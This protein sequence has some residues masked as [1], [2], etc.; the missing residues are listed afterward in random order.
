MF[1]ILRLC[2]ILFNTSKASKNLTFILKQD[3]R[4]PVYSGRF[5]YIW[6]NSLYSPH[7]CIHFLSPTRG[8]PPRFIDALFG[9]HITGISGWN[10][11]C[12]T[13]HNT[14]VW[15]R[16]HHWIPFALV[17]CWVSAPA[18]VSLSVMSGC[19]E[20]RK[21]NRRNDRSNL[22]QNCDVYFEDVM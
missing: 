19:H 7:F 9:V 10:L 2:I 15:L 17:F 4:S 3:W 1:C 16:S 8:L 14:R 5:E 6:W 12:V 20:D 21:V 11:W 18:L 22:F 13:H